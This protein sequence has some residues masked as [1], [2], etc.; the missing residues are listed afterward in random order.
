MD[1][2]AT[3]PLGDFGQAVA[4]PGQAPSIPRGNPIGQAVERTGQVAAQVVDERGMELRRE[5]ERQEAQER[6]ERAQAAEAAART[7]AITTLTGAKDGLADLHDRITRGVLD[8]TVPKAKAESDF[9]A[10]AGKLL[11]GAGGG[12]SQEQ[13]GAVVAELTR[14]AARLSNSVRKA[15]TQRDRQDVTSGISQTLEYLQRQ[16][17]ADPAKATQQAMDLVDQLGP[18]STLN[19]EQLA[20]LK[21]SWKEGTQYTAGYELVSAGRAD[22][23]MLDAAEKTISTGL[24]DIDPQKRA[25]LLDRIAAY[26][27]H[28]DQKAELAAARAQREAERRLKLAE[29]EFNTF[30]VMADKGTILDPAYIDRALTATSGT[31][32]QSGVRALAQ[33]AKDMGG[34][35]A[36]PVQQQ[37]MLL[38]QVN[39]LIAQRGRSPELDKRKDQ[40]E[41]V[42]RGSQQDL[43]RDGLRAGL[44]R[45]VI[46]DLKPLDQSGGIPGLIQQLQARVPLAQRVSM[47]AGRQVSPMTDEEAAQLKHQLD[48]LPAKERSGMVATLAQAIGPQAAQGLAVQMDKKDKGMALAFAFSGS[49]TTEGRFTS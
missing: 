15:V 7:H 16:Y 47:W 25:T 38:D 45:G 14:D 5:R 36:Q 40:I 18:H 19:P 6:Q 29:A 4:R 32:Y 17:R 11:Q 49:Q 37:Q 24:P 34:L 10:E 44:E 46:T 8:G 48:A 23:K 3:I 9:V 1:L 21:Q 43:D 20:K 22:R 42:L 30:Q 13:R 12:L 2:M 27:L 28:L 31:P 35:A 41:K 39:A 26:R 33:Q